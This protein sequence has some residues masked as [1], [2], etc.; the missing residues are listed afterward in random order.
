MTADHLIRR[1]EEL[2]REHGKG[3]LLPDAVDEEL[4]RLEW[5]LPAGYVY[6]GDAIGTGERG[7]AVQR[8]GAGPERPS[9]QPTKDDS[10]EG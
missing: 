5:L 8:P 3:L 4:T 10:K 1:Y 7:P 2:R 6:P 9:T